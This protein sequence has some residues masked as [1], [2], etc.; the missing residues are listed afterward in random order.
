MGRFD[1]G[2][3][4]P[5]DRPPPGRRRYRFGVN[6]QS[7]NGLGV[8]VQSVI[9]KSPASHVTVHETQNGVRTTRVTSMIPGDLIQSVNDRRVR[10]LTEF[11]RALDSIPRGG[12]MRIRGLDAT[13]GWRRGYTASVRLD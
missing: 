10:N 6:L 7:R 9:A 11:Y 8:V 12:Q 2:D 5:D 3:A 1:G 13:Y 4:V